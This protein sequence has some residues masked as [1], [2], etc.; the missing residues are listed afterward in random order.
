MGC[1]ASCVLSNS[2]L[3]PLETNDAVA[4]STRR[5]GVTI[6]RGYRKELERVREAG[7]TS[8]AGD[9]VA[10]PAFLFVVPVVQSKAAPTLILRISIHGEPC[11]ILLVCV[12]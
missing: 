11:E 5:Y 7:K 6:S 1:P 12:G 2:F 4:T 3:C 8:G 10:G 9:A